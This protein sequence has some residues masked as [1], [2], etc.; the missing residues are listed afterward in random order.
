M[1]DFKRTFHNEWGYQAIEFE[2]AKHLFAEADKETKPGERAQ[3]TKEAL[4]ACYT[5]A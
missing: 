5:D 3:L 4:A 1:T 2:L